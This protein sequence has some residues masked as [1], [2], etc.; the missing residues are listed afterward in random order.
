MLTHWF[1]QMAMA[2]FAQARNLFRACY[3]E[4]SSANRDVSTYGSQEL[5]TEGFVF[6]SLN[7]LELETTGGVQ[8]VEPLNLAALHQGI[9]RI[10]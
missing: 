9:Y 3:A 1:V 2:M 4:Y 8:G 7:T 10:C 5:F 6:T